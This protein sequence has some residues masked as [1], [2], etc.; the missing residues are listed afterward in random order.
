M[1]LSFVLAGVIV[2]QFCY[3]VMLDRQHLAERRDLYNRIQGIQTESNRDEGP[4]PKGRSP[5]HSTMNPEMAE[6]LKLDG[7]YK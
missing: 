6:K 1:D 3:I 2:L 4:G 7:I 5:I